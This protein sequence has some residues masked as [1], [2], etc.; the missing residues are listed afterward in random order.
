MTAFCA[1]AVAASASLQL[2]RAGWAVYEP[3]PLA[4]QAYVNFATYYIWVLLDM[5]PGLQASDLLSFDPSLKPKNAVAGVPVIAFRMFVL[6]G[7]LAALR[8]WW[9]GR[10]ESNRDDQA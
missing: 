7:L 2:L 4:D 1:I 10:K 3:T 5:L 9:N 6:F 8:V